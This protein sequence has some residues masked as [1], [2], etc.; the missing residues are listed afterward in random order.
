M[1]D[2]FQILMIVNVG[3][4]SVLLYRVQWYGAPQRQLDELIE[5]NKN[6]YEQIHQNHADVLENKAKSEAKD[7]ITP[8]TKSINYAKFAVIFAVL[9]TI[10]VAMGIYE[11]LIKEYVASTLITI[12]AITC[13]AFS[14][15]CTRVSINQSTRPKTT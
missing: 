10:L 1:S 7:A 8:E 6:L 2:I 11:A 15:N 3:I 9:Y 12:V 5:V 4:F 13:A 14:F